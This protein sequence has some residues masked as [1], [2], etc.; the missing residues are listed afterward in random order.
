MKT[1]IE[2]VYGLPQKELVEKLHFHQ[3]QTEVSD[4]ALGF[5]LLDM[6]RRNAFQPEKDA[7]S[8]AHKH[9]PGCRHPQKLMH[10]A[11]CLE[12]L[13]RMAEAFAEGEIPWTLC[14]PPS[15]P[16]GGRARSGP[17]GHRRDR[18]GL[19]RFRP[20]KHLPGDRARGHG[21]KTR[22]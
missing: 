15:V 6:Q 2:L 13:P 20:E 3:R 22:G 12:E 21:E 18:G 5:Y 14:L 10:L 4:R 17:R 7:T 16:P 8:W 19:A 9:L 1:T 11:E